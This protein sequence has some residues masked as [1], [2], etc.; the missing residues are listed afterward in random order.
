MHDIILGMN[1]QNS[2]GIPGGILK[3]AQSFMA[4]QEDTP[5][6]TPSVSIQ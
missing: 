1:L 3:T 6:N 2:G 5:G 4:K